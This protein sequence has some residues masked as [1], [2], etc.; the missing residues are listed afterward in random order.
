M[1]TSEK[2]KAKGLRGRETRERVIR[3]AA[4]V[5]NKR[6]F[7]G[8]SMS[9]LMDATGLQKGGIYRHFRSKQELA[10]AAMKYTLDAADACRFGH[11][12]AAG[13]SIE[14][15]RQFVTH[16][17]ANRSP[18]A[19]GCPL[20]N[21][22]V[23]HD[24]GDPKLLEEAGRTLTTWLSRLTKIVR[25]GQSHGEIKGN[26]DAATFATS[27]LAA[28]EGAVAMSRLAPKTGALKIVGKQLLDEIDRCVV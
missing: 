5:F 25:H 14:Q 18:V 15:L 24:D 7:A 10:L 17:V 1:A 13:G 11:L 16:F 20:L 8:C 6:G 9:E 28:L 26:V 22:S 21:A 23:D 12:K 2:E 27:M 19:G 3:Q 4:P